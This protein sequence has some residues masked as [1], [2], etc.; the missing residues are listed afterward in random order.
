[1]KHCATC[2][3][4]TQETATE[5]KFLSF[6]RANPNKA[7]TRTDIVQGVYGKEFDG[8]TNVVDVYIHTLRLKYHAPIK[9]VR[10]IGYML[11]VQ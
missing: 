10:G 2:T 8:L 9:T 6:L 3:C 5:S 1:M 7:L 11:E 4:C